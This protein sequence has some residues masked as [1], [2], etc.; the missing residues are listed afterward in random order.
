MLI[1][2]REVDHEISAFKSIMVT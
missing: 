1:S 2:K